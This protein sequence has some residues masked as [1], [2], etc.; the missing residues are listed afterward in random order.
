M[1]YSLGVAQCG[2][3]ET[4]FTSLLEKYAAGLDLATTRL[5]DAFHAQDLVVIRREAHSL[6][7]DMIYICMCVCGHGWS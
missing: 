2:G 6:K 1:D 5:V 7:V 3:N 4:L